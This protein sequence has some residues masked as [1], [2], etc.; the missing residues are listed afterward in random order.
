MTLPGYF[1][2]R[3]PYFVGKRD[4]HILLENRNIVIGLF[5]NQACVLNTFIQGGPAKVRS[6]YIFDGNLNA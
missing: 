5:E 2:D 3:R 4:Q 6:T 1:L